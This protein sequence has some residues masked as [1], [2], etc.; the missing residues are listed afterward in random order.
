MFDPL[1]QWMAE[2]EMLLGFIGIGSLF[3]LIATLFLLPWLVAQIPSDYFSTKQRKPA[4]WKQLHPLLRYAVL[5]LKN[6]VGVIIL[7]AGI[8][9]LLTPGQGLLSILLGLMLMDYPGKFQLERQI[10]TRLKL[11]RFINWLRRKQ[12]KPP[13]SLES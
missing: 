3:L 8:A 5:V 13:L 1:G 6:F 2:H 12:K 9:M 11:L 10:I 7:L 4:Q